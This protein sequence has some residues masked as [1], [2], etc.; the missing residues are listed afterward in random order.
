MKMGIIPPSSEKFIGKYGYDYCSDYGYG[1]GD[2][3][4]NGDG[5]DIF[6]F[7]FKS[8]FKWRGLNSEFIPQLI[9]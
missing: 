1:D 3:Y 6:D 8:K 7:N 4:G 9:D 2:S 5:S